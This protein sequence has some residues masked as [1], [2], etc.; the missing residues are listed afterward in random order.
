MSQHLNQRWAHGG[1]WTILLVLR[2]THAWLDLQILLSKMVSS[3]NSI[4]LIGAKYEAFWF[5]WWAN[6]IRGRPSSVSRARFGSPPGSLCNHVASIVRRPSSVSRVRF[7][8]TGAIVPKLCTH[9]PLCKSNSQTKFRF[10]R[11]LDSENKKNCY[12]S[13]TNGWII[14]KF[15]FRF[16]S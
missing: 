9:A 6:T 4:H 1:L 12:N 2:I 16:I 15:L 8:T 13:W 7:L 3:S 14:S 5:T 11:I 10:T